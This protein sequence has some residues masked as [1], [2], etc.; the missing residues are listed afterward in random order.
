MIVQK[1][2][3]NVAI[4]GMLLQ[5]VFSAG[6]LAIWL[7]TGSPSAMGCTWL[8]AAGVPAWLMAAM[9]LYCRQLARAEAVE[10]EEISRATSRRP[11]ARNSARRRGDWPGSSGGRPR[12]S[13]SCGPP[14]T[15]P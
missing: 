1:R 7:W 11:R 9:L 12:S 6:M 4:A 2:G 10:L 13:P 8:L 15:S 5:M 14:H 3:K